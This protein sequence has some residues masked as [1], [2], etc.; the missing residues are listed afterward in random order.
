[1][2]FIIKGEISF[3]AKFEGVEIVYDCLG[4]GKN[5]GELELFLEME[6]SDIK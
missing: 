3:Y 6:M 1:M 2:F 5:F 4:E